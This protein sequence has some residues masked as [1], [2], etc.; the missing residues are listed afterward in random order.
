MTCEQA[1]DQVAKKYGYK[2]LEFLHM[3]FE[4]YKKLINEAAE[5]YAKSK[6]DKAW[7]DGCEHIENMYE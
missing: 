6:A 1:K 5:L 4:E 7:R 2:N 3:G